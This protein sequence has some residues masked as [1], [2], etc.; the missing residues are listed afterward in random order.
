MDR[1]MDGWREGGRGRVVVVVGGGGACR[2]TDSARQ[3]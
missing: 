3:S 2:Q 1:N